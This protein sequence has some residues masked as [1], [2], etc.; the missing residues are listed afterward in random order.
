MG[1]RLDRTKSFMNKL[2]WIS[3][4]SENLTE[5]NQSNLIGLDLEFDQN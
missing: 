1:K 5:P 4:N 2:G 3:K